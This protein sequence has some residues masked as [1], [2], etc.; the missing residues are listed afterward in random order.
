MLTE[1]KKF[2]TSFSNLSSSDNN[3]NK[4]SIKTSND[5]LE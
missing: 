1:L 2:E 3:Q 5:E 4:G